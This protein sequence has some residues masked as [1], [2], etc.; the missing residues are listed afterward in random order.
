MDTMLLTV[1]A[2]G[3]LNVNTGKITSGGADNPLR[4]VPYNG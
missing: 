4:A 3:S 2:D 1:N